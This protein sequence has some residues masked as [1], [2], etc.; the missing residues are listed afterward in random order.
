MDTSIMRTV[1]L[2]SK[3]P[4]TGTRPTSLK[5]ITHRQNRCSL[6]LVS[7]V[8]MECGDWEEIGLEVPTWRSQTGGL[9][10]Q[11]DEV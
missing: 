9:E 11:L 1:A 10:E 5:Q 2:C 7:S 3:V 8:M 6:L 4:W